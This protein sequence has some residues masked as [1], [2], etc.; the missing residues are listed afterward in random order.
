MGMLAGMVDHVIGVDT[1]ATPQTP[2]CVATA[3]AVCG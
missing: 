1:T 2:R 3:A